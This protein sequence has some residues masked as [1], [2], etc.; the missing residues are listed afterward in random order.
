MAEMGL[1]KA[2]RCSFELEL[3]DL[4]LIRPPFIP[5]DPL[6]PMGMDGHCLV[7]NALGVAGLIW[8]C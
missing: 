2:G 3:L 7:S 4:G 8:T 1:Q 5:R 6:G